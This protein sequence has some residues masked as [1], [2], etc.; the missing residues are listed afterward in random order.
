MTYLAKIISWV[1]HPLLMAT[2]GIILALFNTY[3]LFLPTSMKLLVIG[4]VFFISAFLPASLIL[5]LIKSGAAKDTELTDRNERAV[6]Y[7]I[8]IASIILCIFFLYRL[9]VP[10]WL[11]S[12]LGGGCVALILAVSINFYWKIS[13]H[14]IGIGILTGGVM[15]ISQIQ[16]FNPYIAFMLLFLIAGALC[17]SRIY[18]NKHTPMQTYTGFCLGFA[19]PFISSIW[20]YNHF[21]IK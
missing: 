8:I 20:S 17:T 1:F 21:F 4:G 5:F 13:A 7:L 16:A 19:C 12:V 11:L 9:M 15:G 18:L 6:P 3:L 14:A 10:F 2:Y